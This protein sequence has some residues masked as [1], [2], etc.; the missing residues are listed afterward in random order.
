MACTPT[1]FGAVIRPVKVACALATIAP[2]VVKVPVQP[3]VLSTNANT[4]APASYA[5]LLV[6]VTVTDTEELGAT[7]G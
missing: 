3:N 1:A 7:K 6:I 5:L 4:T 2:L